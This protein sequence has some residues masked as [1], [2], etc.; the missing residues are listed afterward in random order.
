ML[1]TVHFL[2]GGIYMNIRKSVMTVV[3]IV[4][5]EADGLSLQFVL[6]EGEDAKERKVMSIAMRVK[7]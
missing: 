7:S 1:E 3:S 2:L 4:S 5:Y 6:S